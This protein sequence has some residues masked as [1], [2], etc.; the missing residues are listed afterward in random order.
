MYIA[1]C[2]LQH[3][4]IWSQDSNIIKLKME[5]CIKVCILTAPTVHTVLSCKN[6]GQGTV[7]EWKEDLITRDLN[8][9]H[10]GSQTHTLTPN[11]E[12][13]GKVHTPPEQ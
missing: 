7:P 5:N 12:K 3:V 11:S 9:E 6:L 8:Y 13:R 10:L 1:F 4:Q 2:E